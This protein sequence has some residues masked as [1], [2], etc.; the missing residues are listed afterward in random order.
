[1]R[2]RIHQRHRHAKMLVYAAELTEIRQL[3]RSGYVADRREQRVLHDRAEQHV[4][5]EARGP[6][7]SFLHQRR[8]RITLVA[9]NELA[10]LLTD[11]EAASLRTLQMEERQ[12]PV[13]RVYLFVVAARREIGAG[14]R[15]EPHGLTRRGEL[16]REHLAHEPF[17]RR[18]GRID[19]DKTTSAEHARAP[20]P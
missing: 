6:F 19:D 1:R 8:D 12:A 5:T 14:E 11:G 13:V 3:V 10:I 15:R 18:A 17:A 7:R 20:T 9:D 4:G 2:A 16:T